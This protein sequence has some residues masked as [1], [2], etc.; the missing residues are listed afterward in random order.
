MIMYIPIHSLNDTNY[1]YFNTTGVQQHSFKFRNPHISHYEEQ[2]A[3]IQWRSCKYCPAVNSK[4]LAAQAATS[5]VQ[6]AIETVS[7]G[8]NEVHLLSKDRYEV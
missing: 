3:E 7:E 2:A 6:R 4:H 5:D 1:G 8:T